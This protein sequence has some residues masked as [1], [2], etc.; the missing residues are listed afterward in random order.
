MSS[1]YV[2][3]ITREKGS[4]DHLF[5]LLKSCD[6][7]VSANLI[8]AFKQSFDWCVAL[9]LPLTLCDTCPISFLNSICQN[10]NGMLTQN[11]S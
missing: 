7:K 8:K 11:V 9:S 1:E 6:A 2:G 3:L 5:H 10:L 4:C